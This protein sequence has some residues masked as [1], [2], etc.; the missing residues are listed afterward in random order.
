MI[1]SKEI[2]PSPT[3]ILSDK[4]RSLKAQ[5]KKI[6]S[7]AIG[8]PDFKTPSYIIDSTIKAL[9]EGYTGYSTPQG[10]IELR[11]SIAK[12][13]NNTYK[14]NYEASEVIILPGA[15]AAIY[16]ALA[17]ILEPH[18][19]VIIISPYYVSYPGIIKLAEPNSKIIDIPM[20]NFKLPLEQIK[21]NI[22]RN[23]RCLILNYPNNPAGGLLDK[24]EMQAVVD[25]VE[26]NNFYLLSDEIYDKMVFEGNVF[27]SFSSYPAIKDKLILINGF[28]K[29]Y[30]MTGF[31]IGYA[32]ASNKVIAKMNIFNQNTNTNTNTF[33]QKGCLSVYDNINTHIEPYNKLLESRAMYM[34]S[35]INKLPYFK[36]LMPKGAFYM[37]VDI[38]ETNMT[39]NDFANYLMDDYGLVVAPGIAFG[40]FFDSYIR[41][42]LA[43]TIDV[44]EEVIAI[45]KKVTF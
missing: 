23:T 25:L 27:Y 28:S 15:K 26:N 18:D 39:S 8:E 12:D 6:I 32:I 19:E 24:L 38:S 40:P 34:Y 4:A 10:L 44:L 5:G 7:L 35:E 43:T 21:A 31:R 36:A 16:A 17:S 2:K 22:T 37:F 29:T 41:I 20:D 13:Y 14:A 11:S 45:L 9:K 3:L 33:V 1:F 42:S 30:A